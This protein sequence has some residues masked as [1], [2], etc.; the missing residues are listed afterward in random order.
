M[1]VNCTFQSGQITQMKH[2]VINRPQLQS[3]GYSFHQNRLLIHQE[4]QQQLLHET[5]IY[6]KLP[7][8]FLLQRRQESDTTR[9]KA[10]VGCDGD[11][12]VRFVY[13]N[14]L[15]SKN[16]IKYSMTSELGRGTYSRVFKC[17]RI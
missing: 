12:F 11:G 13:D 3:C 8:S 17:R 9:R 14:V 7:A 16:N 4:S 5:L 6:E 10:Y 15:C 1:N 2:S